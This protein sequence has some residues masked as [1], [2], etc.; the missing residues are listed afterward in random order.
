MNFRY[1]PE[2][3]A[4]LLSERGIGF[5][6]IIQ[7]IVDGNILQISPHYNIEKYPNQKIIY[8]RIVQE[9]FV[10]PCVQEKEGHFFLKTLFPSRKAKKLLLGLA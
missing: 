4:Q 9:V 5:E 8:V 7:A 1:N 2:K 6:E 10:V 3:N